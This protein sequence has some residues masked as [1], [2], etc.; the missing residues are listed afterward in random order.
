MGWLECSQPGMSYKCRRQGRQMRPRTDEA[1]KYEST[2]VMLRNV[3]DSQTFH[4]TP[5]K[6]CCKSVGPSGRLL[7]RPA[8]LCKKQ[9]R[10]TRCGWHLSSGKSILQPPPVRSAYFKSRSSMKSLSH[11]LPANREARRDALA[12]GLCCFTHSAML[13]MSE[14]SLERWPMSGTL[15]YSSLM[16]KCEQAA[17]R[18][19]DQRKGTHTDHSSPNRNLRHI[20]SPP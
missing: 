13:E 9:L 19:S 2:Q 12:G 20:C 18:S 3:L 14:L 8:L 5:P 10:A 15:G 16:S 17:A 7:G 6:D 1:A 11:H 4:S